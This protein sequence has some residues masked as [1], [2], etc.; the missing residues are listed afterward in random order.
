MVYV[1]IFILVFVYIQHD[2]FMFWGS[3]YIKL[4]A[5]VMEGVQNGIGII[6]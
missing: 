5:F 1:P 4:A 2:W 3:F 6:L